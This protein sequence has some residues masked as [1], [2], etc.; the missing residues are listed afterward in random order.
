L[1]LH[2]SGTS[3]HVYKVSNQSG[4]SFIAPECSDV[5]RIESFE[6]GE[7]VYGARREAAFRRSADR[8]TASASVLIQPA[9]RL[10][11]ADQQI[12]LL[13]QHMQPLHG[14]SLLG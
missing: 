14:Q 10:L 4:T 8:L 6:L 13:L 1:N 2:L 7:S 5:P 3:L 9:A 11:S 12:G